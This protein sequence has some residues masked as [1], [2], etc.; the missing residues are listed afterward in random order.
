MAG[1]KQRD[2]ILLAIYHLEQAMASTD[3]TQRA[4]LLDVAIDKLTAA[5]EQGLAAQIRDVM[6]GRAP[7]EMAQFIATKLK[8]H[9]S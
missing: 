5:R 3:D 8:E 1:T 7:V 9:Y 6:I 2:F 4:A